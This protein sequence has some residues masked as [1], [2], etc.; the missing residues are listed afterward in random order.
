MIQK[1][2]MNF[3]QSFLTLVQALA[4]GPGAIVGLVVLIVVLA[5]I[6]RVLTAGYHTATQALPEFHPR[7]YQPNGQNRTIW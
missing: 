6:R 3:S 4:Y 2:T 7:P 5:V 1:L